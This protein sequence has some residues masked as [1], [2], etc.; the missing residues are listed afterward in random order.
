ML[1]SLVNGYEVLKEFFKEIWLNHYDPTH[2]AYG[3]SGCFNYSTGVT[4]VVI[5]N[6][7]GHRAVRDLDC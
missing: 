4:G 1:F 6:Q 3:V 2:K 5:W 7:I